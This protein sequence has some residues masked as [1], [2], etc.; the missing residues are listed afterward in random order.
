V[1]LPEIH[2]LPDS[3]NVDDAFVEKVYLEKNIFTGCHPKL[4]LA[5]LK[6]A[7]FRDQ[8][9]DVRLQSVWGWEV[10]ARRKIVMLRTPAID[11]TLT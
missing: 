9:I 10:H 6:S 3:A 2:D 7:T 5:K 4:L 8:I 1:T 11:Y